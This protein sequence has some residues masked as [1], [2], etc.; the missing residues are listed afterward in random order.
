MRTPAVRLLHH[1]RVHAD[2]G[3]TPGEHRRSLPAG[4]PRACPHPAL[5][6]SPCPTAAVTCVGGLFPEAQS[7]GS[8]SGGH[9]GCQGPSGRSRLAWPQA[10]RMSWS[11]SGG[12]GRPGAPRPPHPPALSPAAHTA[13][14][15]PCCA[16]SSCDAG[17]G[18][19]PFLTWSEHGLSVQ[20]MG[21]RAAGP[22][23]LCPRE[24]S[25]R[26]G[27]SGF[28]SH[29]GVGVLPPPRKGGSPVN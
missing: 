16:P 20:G 27:S 3:T 4:T 13:G 25:R 23:P 8:P 12:G 24:R 17:N 2:P 21:P 18:R 7:W 14:R 1:A 9:I 10:G 19:G 29:S 6:C 22:A 26:W 28:F 15:R 11:L 5:P